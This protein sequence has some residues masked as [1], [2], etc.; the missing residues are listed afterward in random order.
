MDAGIETIHV[1]I[2]AVLTCDLRLNTPRFTSLPQ[3]MKA[4]SKPLETLLVADLGV[5]IAPRT[6]VINITEPPKRTA[7]IKVDTVAQLIEKINH[8]SQS[9]IRKMYV[10]IG[11]C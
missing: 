10:C 5:D 4:K 2:P 11:H 6:Q 7:G 1:R 3:I 8:R 9:I